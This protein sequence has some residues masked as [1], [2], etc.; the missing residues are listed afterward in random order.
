MGPSRPAIQA[1][2]LLHV[3]GPARVPHAPVTH[4]HE[5]CAAAPSGIV[6]DLRRAPRREGIVTGPRTATGPRTG[7]A[8]AVSRRLR[9]AA[10]ACAAQSRHVAACAHRCPR[11]GAVCAPRRGRTVV[12]TVAPRHAPTRRCGGAAPR[13][14]R[15][16]GVARRGAAAPGAAAPR[17]GAAPS[18]VV[19]VVEAAVVVAAVRAAAAAAAAGAVAAA[20][21]EAAASAAAAAVAPAASRLSHGLRP[22]ARTLRAPCLLLHPSQAPRRCRHLPLAGRD[23]AG[24]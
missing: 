7:V 24:R 8:A 10:A 23:H 2:P 6:R 13:A 4:P 11:R 22:L 9:A 14:G 1:P 15:R 21:A 12:M 17:R 20:A 19:V 3:R 16:R 18:A 5:T